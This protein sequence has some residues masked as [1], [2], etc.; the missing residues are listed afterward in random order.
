M[1]DRKRVRDSIRDAKKKEFEERRQKLLDARQR[2]KDSI[3]NARNAGGDNPPP[4]DG[5]GDGNGGI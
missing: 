5:D 1:E 4:G 2:R 3:L